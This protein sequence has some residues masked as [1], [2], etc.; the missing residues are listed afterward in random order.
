LTKEEFRETYN[1]FFDSIRSYLFYRSGNTEL[2]T[3]IAQETFLKIWQKQIK[4]HPQKTKAMLYKIASDMFVNHIRRE[5]VEG[6]YL[7]TIKLNFIEKGHDTTLEYEELKQAYEKALA[8]LPE[9]QRVVFLMSR[10]EDFTYQEIAERLQISVKAVEKRMSLAL[11][12]LR[13]VIQT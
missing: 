9:K 2:S 10:M 11:A 5:K 12:E 13:K 7:K 4:Y 3:D 1:R 8:K 6:D